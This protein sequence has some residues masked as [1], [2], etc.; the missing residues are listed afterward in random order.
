MAQNTDADKCRNCLKSKPSAA[1]LKPRW[2]GRGSPRSSSGGRICGFRFRSVS[3]NGSPANA[4]R[5]FGG[6]QNI[7]SPISTARRSSS[8]TLAC[9]GLSAS[10]KLGGRNPR[11]GA[12]KNSLHDHVAFDLST[13]ARVVYNDPRRFGFMQ[14][15]PRPE[16]AAHPLFNN[17]GIEPLGD[18]FDGAALAQTF[19][20]EDNVAE[21][22]APRS[23]LDC[24]AWQYLCL[25]GFA[26]RRSVAAPR[27][28][29]PRMQRRLP[30]RAGNAPGAHD[31]APF[32]TRRW[33]RAGRRCAIIER[34]MARSAISSIVFAFTAAPVS[35]ARGAAA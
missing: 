16:I 35:V 23:G 1:G 15:I 8:C 29:E 27:R 12:R 9:Q 32:S 18:E 14:L 31:L 4:S 13:G 33:R 30:K 11:C 10:N 21:S 26:S 6:G 25:R 7:S 34:P 3:R 20:G 24:R 28:R 22:R 17:V 19:C 5:R 2:S